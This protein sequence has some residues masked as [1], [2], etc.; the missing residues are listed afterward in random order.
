M[1]A[2]DGTPVAVAPVVT[3]D[4]VGVGRVTDTTGINDITVLN[5]AV[6]VAVDERLR[7]NIV[8]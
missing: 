7:Q 1:Y 2:V 6:V 5:P 4:R 3:N 8:A